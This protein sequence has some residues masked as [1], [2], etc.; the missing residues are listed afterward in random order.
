[1]ELTGAPA[2]PGAQQPL[3][4]CGAT[5][6]NPSV[7]L[8]VNALPLQIQLQPL[9]ASAPNRGPHPLP[10]LTSH[11]DIHTVYFSQPARSLGQGRSLPPGFVHQFGMSWLTA[12]VWLGWAAPER[13]ICAGCSAGSR[14]SGERARFLPSQLNPTRQ[15]G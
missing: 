12:W 7:P 13:G 9:S 6:E 4:D 14:R 5:P 1:M 15:Q 11:P 8:S 3:A 10:S 2:A